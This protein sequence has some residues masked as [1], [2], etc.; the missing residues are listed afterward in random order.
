MLPDFTDMYFCSEVVAHIQ[1]LRPR[2]IYH[3]PQVALFGHL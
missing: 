2:R 1:H 3:A